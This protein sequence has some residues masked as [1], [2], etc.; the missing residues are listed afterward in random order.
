[1]RGTGLWK[2]TKIAARA[3]MV[4]SVLLLAMNASAQE[5]RK[6]IAG[7]EPTYPEIAKAVGLKGV[8]KVQVV[9]GAD[10]TIKDTKVIGGHPMLVESVKDVLKKWKYAPSGSETVTILEFAFHP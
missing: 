3:V 4:A 1:M 9:I 2:V 8:V 5:K 6:L 7:P 10:G